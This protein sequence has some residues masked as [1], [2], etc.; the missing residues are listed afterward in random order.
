MR[1]KCMFNLRLIM[2]IKSSNNGSIFLTNGY[3]IMYHK[4][5]VHFS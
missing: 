2:M 5:N 1:M 3:S 4:L